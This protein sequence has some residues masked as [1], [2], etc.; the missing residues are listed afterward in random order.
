MFTIIR[1]A[2]VFAP[3]DLG[4]LDVLVVGHQIAAI[5][6]MV[7]LTSNQVPVEEVDASDLYLLP[8][9]I[10][11]H[12]HIAGGGGEGGF[13][14]RTPEISLSQVT[15]AGVTT[16]VGVLGTDGITRG[17]G[18]LLAKAK[19][20]EEDGI[21]TY[22]YCGA[23]ELPARTL[24]GTPQG[25]LV[26][27]DK[28]I[29]VGEI[30]ISDTR[31][32][33][34]S[35]QELAELASEARVGGL[36]GAKAGVIHLHVGDDDPGLN[37][38]FD[39]TERTR[40]PRNM[41]VPTHLNR[42]PSLMRDAIRW[43]R[44]GGVVDITSGI[45]PDEHDTV[46]IKPS[47]AVRMLLDSGISPKQITMSSDSNGSSPIFD[48]SGRLVAMG[49]GSIA[50]LW[51]EIHDCIVDEN[52]PVKDAVGLA[53]QHV[54]RILQLSHKGSVQPGFDADLLLVDA[55]FNI[56]QV[57]AKGRLMVQE[58]R[59]VVMGTFEGYQKRQLPSS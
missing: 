19:A 3:E 25:D 50:T 45:R 29:G 47:K 27:I 33:H 12:V 11:Q 46:S 42:N 35:E 41:F 23:Y 16:L 49:I 52:I 44:L 17:T 48:D 40:L 28:V 59:P 24:T 37:I 18:E 5:A 15:T 43:A 51:E 4:K 2:R 21:S 8:G 7:E 54:A 26:F 14:Y 13:H 30:A 57:Y 22:I 58:G 31:S 10:D 36:L 9:L 38:L 1:N 39:L 56:Q 55:D 34:P 32:S 53:T 6:P 20:L